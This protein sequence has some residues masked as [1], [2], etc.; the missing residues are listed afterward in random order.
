MIQNSKKRFQLGHYNPGPGNAQ[1]CLIN[2]DTAAISFLLSARPQSIPNNNVAHTST[3]T[4]NGIEGSDVGWKRMLERLKNI[5]VGLIY[6][7]WNEYAAA[8]NDGDMVRWI[9]LWS[10]D[11][12]QMA[13][14]APPRVGR[15]QIREAM[16]P[17]FDRFNV[18]NMVI[19]IEEVRILG[20]WAYS[21]GTYAF[22]L[23]SKEGGKTCGYSGKFLDI[24]VKKVDGS[25]QIAID[26]HNYYESLQPV[27]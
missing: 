24:V 27:W 7:L 14:D 25:W 11:G 20:D 23:A 5:D 21:Y 26:C 3:L 13:P 12:V 10:D 6:D 9:S 18:S 4:H 15:R 2:P 19:N 22:D 17:T 8:A 16:Q 1:W